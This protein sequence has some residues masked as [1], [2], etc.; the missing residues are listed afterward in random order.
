[1]LP[2]ELEGA[3]KDL[4]EQLGQMTPRPSWR[5]TH[6][7]GVQEGP[8]RRTQD[9]VLA[10]AQKLASL[11][12]AHESSLSQSAAV[13]LLLAPEPPPR[14]ITLA[15]ATDASACACCMARDRP[16]TMHRSLPHSLALP[17]RLP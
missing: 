8:G 10:A 6:R 7:H 1:M 9:L 11:S 12:A 5:D 17:P 16:L 4:L 2:Q 14:E 15:I 3:Q 13:Q